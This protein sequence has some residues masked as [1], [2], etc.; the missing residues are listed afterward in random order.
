MADHAVV[1][2]EEW[3]AA[4][5]ELLED[6]KQLT[7]LRDELNRRRRALPWVKVEATYVFEGPSGKETLADLF[8]GRSQLIIH[9]FMF[10]P[11]WQEGCIGCSFHSDHAEGA[12]VHLENHD[13][14]FVR[15]SRAPLAKIEAFKRRMGWT[16]PW[17]SSF[18]NDFNYDFQVTIDES[19][20]PLE[21]NYRSKADH[22]RVGTAADLGH[23][24]G[25]NT[26]VVLG[27]VGEHPGEHPHPD[28]TEPAKNGEEHP[29]VCDQ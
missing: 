21:Y 7:R 2:R 16:L 25:R 29:P 8:A 26:R 12:L 3:V 5:K 28:E 13:V 24:H 11:E 14:S 23:L 17:Y 22:E 10:G 19:V 6:E 15:V 20:A 1:S 4:R 27:T 9:H 18:G